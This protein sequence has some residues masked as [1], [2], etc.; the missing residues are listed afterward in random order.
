VIERAAAGNGA[1]E[2]RI[3]A[4]DDERPIDDG[5]RDEAQGRD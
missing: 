5:K 4:F 2:T 1:Q 3:E